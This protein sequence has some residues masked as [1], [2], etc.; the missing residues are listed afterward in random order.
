MRYRGGFHQRGTNDAFEVVINIAGDTTSKPV[1]LAMGGVPFTTGMDG[2]GET[3]YRPCKYTKST[4]SFRTS[5]YMMSVYASGAQD[6]QVILSRNDEVV[7][8]GYATPNLYDMGFARE[9]ETIDIEC[10]DALSTLQYYKFERGNSGIITFSGL[11]SKCLQR[12]NAY[13]HFY[14]STNTQK[15]QSGT[16]EFLSHVCI[17]EQNFFDEK[18]DNETDEDVAWTYRKVLEEVC[19]FMGVTAVAIGSEVFFVDYDALK[20]GIN[21][22]YKY[23]IGSDAGELV[24]VGGNKTITSADFS[25]DDSSISLDQV[26]NKVRVKDSLYAFD[27]LIPGLFSG[28]IIENVTDSTD[29][30]G[31][32]VTTEIIG[33]SQEGRH[34]KVMESEGHKYKNFYKFWKNPYYVLGHFDVGSYIGE[35]YKSPLGNITPDTYPEKINYTKM[36]QA[37]GCYLLSV[38]VNQVSDYEQQ[39]SSITYKDYVVLH[40]MGW[41]RVN[42]GNDPRNQLTADDKYEFI[43]S[44]GST[45][46]ASFFG[47]GG[48]YIIVKGKVRCMNNLQCFPLND[49]YVSDKHRN[50]FGDRMWLPCQ[51]KLG[52]YY[53]NG[54]SWQSS[55]CKFKLYFSES[56]TLDTGDDKDSD[57]GL[58]AAQFFNRDFDFR[59]T[60]NYEDGLKEDGYAIPLANLPLTIAKPEFIIYNPHH[61]V[62][63]NDIQSVWLSDFQIMAAYGN[64]DGVDKNSDTI[65]MNLINNG[66]VQELGTITMKICTWD[67]KKPNYSAPAYR[68]GDSYEYIDK[69]FNRACHQG[70]LVWYGSDKAGTS[71][72]SGLRQEEHLIYRLVNQYRSPSIILTLPLRADN[73]F[74]GTYDYNL[75]ILSGKTFVCDQI[76]STNWKANTQTIKL[77]EKK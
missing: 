5:D 1:D 62:V 48:S 76:N 41:D 27:D 47:G 64:P 68:T 46:V 74:I 2:G 67:N 7:W 73:S 25:G 58:D 15:Q 75:P 61:M 6:V 22:Y 53:W 59:N 30:G 65:Y 51:L 44:N 55:A 39:P 13:T 77:I 38:S 26:Y 69:L 20:A 60:A 17:S 70:E 66:S 12:C 18:K 34:E 10:I 19:R 9:R 57:G 63:N 28:K 42:I 4:A 14:F 29:A 54:S 56:D 43:K 35:Y 71:G 36:V 40:W 16:S 23:A 50:N 72:A 49:V 11:I 45:S 21:T 3:L 31:R 32:N 8:T 52:G 24:T 33:A 37:M